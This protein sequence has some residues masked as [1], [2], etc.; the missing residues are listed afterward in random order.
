MVTVETLFLK[1]GL[2]PATWHAELVGRMTLEIPSL[3]PRLFPKDYAKRMDEL[4]RFRHRFRHV[5]EDGPPRRDRW[6]LGGGVGGL[7]IL[8][9]ASR[10]VQRFTGLE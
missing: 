2:D 8:D 1:N 10:L 6:T 9:A 7:Q 3:R 4:R 5:Y